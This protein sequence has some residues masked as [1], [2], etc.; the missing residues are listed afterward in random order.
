MDG[1]VKKQIFTIRE[2][3]LTNMFDTRYVRYPRRTAHRLQYGLLRAG[4]F[5]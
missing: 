1:K 3:G 2:T 5:S 4:A